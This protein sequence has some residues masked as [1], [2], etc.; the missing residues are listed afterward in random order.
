MVPVV[1]LHNMLTIKQQTKIFFFYGKG[2]CRKVKVEDNARIRCMVL[3]HCVGIF[4]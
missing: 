2:K 4:R 1:V 3:R